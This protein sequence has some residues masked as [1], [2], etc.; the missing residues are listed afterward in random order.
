M[1]HNFWHREIWIFRSIYL[2]FCCLIKLPMLF[3]KNVK[4][5]KLILVKQYSINN[6]QVF[7]QYWKH[8]KGHSSSSQSEILTEANRIKVICKKPSPAL[9]FTNCNFRPNRTS[10]L[11]FLNFLKHTIPQY[12]YFKKKKQTALLIAYRLPSPPLPSPPKGGI[13]LL[14]L[15]F[16]FFFHIIFS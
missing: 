14:F 13:G 15:F 2:Q 11:S 8:M 5:K 12:R 3:V 1:C 4:L 16:F 9:F 6:W 10:P 7:F